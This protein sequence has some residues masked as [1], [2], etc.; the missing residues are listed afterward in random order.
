MQISTFE[1]HRG[2][3]VACGFQRDGQWMYTGSEDGTLKVWDL[4]TPTPQRDYNHLGAV[5]C[6]VLHPNQVPW[7]TRQRGARVV[8]ATGSPYAPA[9]LPLTHHART[10]AAEQLSSRS[11]PGGVR[12]QGELI[13]GDQNG[14]IKI[15]DL[16]ANQCMH[17]LV[18]AEGVPAG[19][20]G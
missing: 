9:S 13:S 5:T 20:V 1:G 19:Y 15:W 8:S 16:T 18:P 3:V 17:E 6:V 7:R 2:N 12:G 10:P 11:A 4:R 14:S